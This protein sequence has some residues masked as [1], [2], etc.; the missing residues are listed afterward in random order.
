M[1]VTG[2]KG[3]SPQ[4]RGDSICGL[5]NFAR[6]I[7][8]KG[9]RN[10]NYNLVL[11]VDSDNPGTLA[12]AFTNAANYRAALP[13]ETFKM[14]LVANGPAVKLFTRGEE[15]LASQGAEIAAQGLEIRLCNNA[16]TKFGIDPAQI[17]DCATVVPAGVVEL[18]RLQNEGYSYIK[19]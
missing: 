5:K 4:R 18:V 11:H 3:A 9:Q 13:G 1:K 8:C 12:L 10:M 6:N 19:P 2:N 15:A 7:L 14:V 17:W 16:L